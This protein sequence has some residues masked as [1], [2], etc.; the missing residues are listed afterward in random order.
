MVK[1]MLSRKVKN[2]VIKVNEVMLSRQ[3]K[4]VRLSLKLFYC[5]V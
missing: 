4:I 5:I 2:N 3:L 1:I